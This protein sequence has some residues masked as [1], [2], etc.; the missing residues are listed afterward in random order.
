MKK[1]FFKFAFATAIVAAV[2][3]GCSSEKAASG[4][5]STKVDS[6]GMMSTPASDTTARDTMK[7]DTT[8]TTPPN[9]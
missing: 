1:Q 4:T 7:T 8:K 2:A 6:T 5:D 9:N 3:A